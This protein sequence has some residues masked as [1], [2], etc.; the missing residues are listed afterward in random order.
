[1]GKLPRQPDLERLRRLEPALIALPAGTEVARV[2]F[3]GG[4]HPTHWN[5]FRYFGPT[6]ARFDHHVSD[7]HGNGKLQDRGVVYLSRSALTCFAEVFQSPARR[8][9]RSRNSP[10]LAA[11]ELHSKVVLL[12][13]S[14][15]FPVRAGA[16]M[17]LM[18]RPTAYSRNWAR[19]F[20]DAY[21]ALQGLYYPSSLTNEP[22]IALNERADV[23]GVF[24]PT[25]NFNRALSDPVLLTPLRNAA[26]DL[27]YDL[28]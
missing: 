15:Q 14:A 18:S 26:E 3:R 2:Y 23:N 7:E 16:S 17:K 11:F 5:A 24:P 25:P 6:E 9:N 19:G 27:G 1:M 12:D 22:A 28:I 4:N 13:L 20:Y 8:I 21:P 10:W